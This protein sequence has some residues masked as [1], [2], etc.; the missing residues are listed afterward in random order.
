MLRWTVLVVIAALAGLNA[1]QFMSRPPAPPSRRAQ[2]RQLIDDFHRLFYDT[3]ST[4]IEN[5]WLGVLCHQNPNDAWIHQEI[6]SETRPDFIVECGTF[7]GGSA[8]LWATILQQ[9]NPEGKVITID[10]ATKLSAEARKLPLARERVV[11]LEGSSTDPRTVA[12]VAELVKGRRVLVILDSLHTK[13]HVRNELRAYAPFVPVGGYLIVQDSN[14]NG[15]P[16]Y[17]THGPGPMEAIEEFLARTDEFV[18]DR[19]RERMLLTMHPK[20][21]LKRVKG[22]V[23]VG[24]R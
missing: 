18:A 19:S 1:Y 4:W 16:V 17:P 7:H 6:I 24:P 20:G 15:H 8:L 14:V 13:E 2:A 10:V 11:F 12:K 21:Y 23:P 9:V 22:H 5:R 3:S